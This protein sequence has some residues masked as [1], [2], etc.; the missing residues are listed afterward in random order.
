MRQHLNAR[1][2]TSLWFNRVH[3]L[4]RS[5]Q[6]CWQLFGSDQLPGY[7][8][9]NDLWTFNGR[10]W[11]KILSDAPWEVRSG[12]CAVI[13]PNKILGIF[14][15]NGRY[16]QEPWPPMGIHVPCYALR[17][18]NDMCDQWWC[19][20]Q[21]L[22]NIIYTEYIYTYIYMC[23]CR[24]H[25]W[26]HKCICEHPICLFPVVISCGLGCR[27]KW[28]TRPAKEMYNDVW[29]LHLNSSHVPAQLIVWSW[30]SLQQR[31]EEKN[32][33]NMREL[34]VWKNWFKCYACFNQIHVWF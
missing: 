2:M 26:N 30:Q 4:K 12:L 1:K 16:V 10:S 15:G 24:V 11:S 28:P 20:R 5:T 18:F 3:Q 34:L 23:V 33:K 21:F 19:I 8:K 14:G 27:G 6:N 13:L 9:F 25:L 17:F 22:Y 7:M 31:D 32:W 29:S